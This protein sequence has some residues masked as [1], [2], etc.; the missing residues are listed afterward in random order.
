MLTLITSCGRADL[1]EKTIKSLLKDQKTKLTVVVNEDV[2]DVKKSEEC[3]RVANKLKCHTIGTYRFGQHKAIENFIAPDL[4]SKYLLHVEDDWFFVNYYN[5]IQASI[6][7][8]E[9]DPTIIKV[10]CRYGSPHPC[11]HDKILNGIEYGY[12]EPWIGS[13]S[14]K[15][16]GFSWNPGVTRLDLLKSLSPFPQYEQGLAEVIHEK[17][18]K[19][20]ELKNGIYTHIGDGRSTH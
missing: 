8:M 15:W 20:V 3:F 6:D 13:D 1:L 16:H 12:V 11:T 9:S 19:I 2:Y 7:I 4:E 17:G 14:I 5:W 10:L 18:Y